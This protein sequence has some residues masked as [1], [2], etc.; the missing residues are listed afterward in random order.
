MKTATITFHAA[1]NYG[2]MLQAYALQQTILNLGHE[3]VILNLR[4]DKQKELYAKI[5]NRKG[6]IIK[7]MSRI[8]FY[9]QYLHA[10]NRKYDLFEKFL[11]DD[12]LLTRE[13]A[14]LHDLELADLK[15]DC[16]ISGGDQIWNTSPI[17]FDWSYYLPFAK[18][19][20]K[21]S[22]AVSMGPHAE[23]QVFNQKKIKQ[24]LSSYTHI[25]V[26]EKGTYDLVSS[27]V[28]IPVEISLDPVFLLTREDWRGKFNKQR[29]LEDEYILVYS[30]GYKPEVYE[31]AEKVSKE[32]NVK[33]VTTLYTPQMAQYRNLKK[34][35][36][37]GP[38]EFLNLL[39]HAKFI[40]SGSFHATA[41]S[42]NLHTE[43]ICVYPKEFGGRLESILRQ[44]NTT[45]RHIDNYED[46]DVVN[47]AV[48]F[49]QVDEILN[50][51]RNKANNFIDTVIED[52]LKQSKKGV[53]TK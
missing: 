49:K 6:G 11:H 31:I 51:E 33:I 32:I 19:G 1:H 13:Y 38:W 22:Y 26:R 48:D 29:L 2:S 14:T 16:F 42:L 43:P 36:A 23:L 44:T 52:V 50:G 37:V 3:N 45:Q 39:D 15:Y 30:P 53:N 12:L 9:F 21:I 10:L 46:F 4:T 40:V 18:S 27:L 35:L 47:R 20:K 34:V 24:Y 25:S 17:D 7:K 5:C 8:F 41:F 28:A